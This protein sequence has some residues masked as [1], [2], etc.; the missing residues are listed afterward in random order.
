MLT[1][2]HSK[3]AKR[4]EIHCELCIV[5][6][7]TKSVC[8]CLS[9][10]GEHSNILEWTCILEY[11]HWLLFTA[12]SLT[13]LIFV[14]FFCFFKWPRS[15]LQNIQNNCTINITVKFNTWVTC[16]TLK[17]FLISQKLLRRLIQDYQHSTVKHSVFNEESYSIGWMYMYPASSYCTFYFSF[18]LRFLSFNQRQAFKFL[19]NEINKFS[20]LV[21]RI[22]GNKRDVQRRMIKQI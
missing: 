8:V 3:E 16:W 9:A 17:M 7:S 10:T 4:N 22:V 5:F 20:C 2:K 14:M 21:T 18:C 13:T 15:H 1:F 19:I 6:N 11:F 12:Y